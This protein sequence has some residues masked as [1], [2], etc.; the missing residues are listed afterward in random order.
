MLNRRVWDKSQMPPIIITK[1]TW[2]VL[3]KRVWRSFLSSSK[4]EWHD[5]SFDGARQAIVH[6]TMMAVVTELAFLLLYGESGLEQ[7]MESATAMFRLAAFRGYA[8]AQMA[9]AACY[10]EGFGAHQNETL[11][12]LWASN[13]RSSQVRICRPDGQLAGCSAGLAVECRVERA[14]KRGA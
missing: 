7:D 4:H 14:A 2:R 1:H 6:G 3:T 12:I 11:S 13:A 9:L 8:P 10:H 5:R